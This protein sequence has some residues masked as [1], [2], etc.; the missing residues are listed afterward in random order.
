MESG[1]CDLVITDYQLRWTDGLSVLRA[2]KANWP[3]CPVIMFTGTGS[4]EIAVEAMKA[5]LDDYVLKASRHYVRLAGA[6]RLAL[7]RAAQ[8][9]ALAESEANYRAL[10]GHVPIGLYKTT[11]AGKIIDANPAMVQM[12][13]HA[14]REALLKVSA[15][16]LYVDPAERRRWQTLM[17]GDGVIRH[18]ETR[19]QRSDGTVIWV[20]D[21]S[22]AVRSR[23]G[24]VLHY[25]GSLEDITERLH[26][27][28][29]L[30]QAQKM[31][32][33]G[34]LAAGVA[35]DFNNILTIIKGHADLLLTRQEVPP[36]I[37]GPLEKI[38]SAADRAA[39]VTTQLLAFSRRQAMRH[40]VLDLN[41]LVRKVV[42]TPDQG[43]G[44]HIS[45]RFDLATNLPPLHA[46]RSLIEQVITNLV[47]NGFDAMRK[48]GT[49][50]VRTAAVEID[51]QYVL[52]NPE[53]IA[54]S[55]VCLSVSDTGA[56]MPPETIGRVF[57]P[58]FTTQEAGRGLGLGLPTAHGITKLHQGWIEAN[59]LLGQGTTF[60]VFLP[61]T[62]RQLEPLLEEPAP[63]AI[64]GG[65]ETILVVEDEPELRSLAR[66]ILEYYGYR[67]LEASGESGALT[68]WPRHAREIDLLLTDV[69]MPEGV[70]GWELASKLRKQKPQL[71]VICTSG[72]SVDLASQTTAQERGFHFLEKP[73]KPQSLVLAVRECLDA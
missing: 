16:D 14:D 66:E 39:R 26:L 17:E 10:F 2:I 13:G 12:L 61:T 54:G 46:D 37:V 5:G 35:H 28:T 60:K 4:E 58:F 52:H 24:E 55:F 51:P 30:L 65:A 33:V 7:E 38:S 8:R 62:S 57:D 70:S 49:L 59:S 50:T 44:R 63:T 67:V 1:D 3:D 18:F 9:R 11:R 36:E 40:R 43:L 25:E 69:L 27:E 22:R 48:G 29:K 19:M 53:A 72:Y 56:G 34:H 64:R 45:L 6:A 32:S 47:V 31:E 23:K 41:D 73:F 71:K 68:M 15:A 20:E 42:A 21:N